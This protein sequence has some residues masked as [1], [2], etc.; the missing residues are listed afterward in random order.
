MG[1][2]GYQLLR[3]MIHVDFVTLKANQSQYV[4]VA[5]VGHMHL[6]C[7]SC[8]LPLLA[9]NVRLLMPCPSLSIH[10]VESSYTGPP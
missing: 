6:T 3:L 8:L 2:F 10:N 4:A 9:A 7:V 5:V 1:Y